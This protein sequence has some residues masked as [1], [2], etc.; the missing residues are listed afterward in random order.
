MGVLEVIIGVFVVMIVL[1]I[2]MQPIIVL[3]DVAEE[4]LTIASNTTKMGT[5]SDGQIVEVGG[6]SA[7]P[8]LTTMFMVGV[9]LF[10][11][12]GFIIWI[13]RTITRP[14]EVFTDQFL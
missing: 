2:I 13:V 12:L 1:V 3:N 6:S 9:G 14:S 7:L 10:I 11:L 4:Q 8:Q 5:N